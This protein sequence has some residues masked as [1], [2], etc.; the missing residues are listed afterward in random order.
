MVMDFEFSIIQE[1]Q[2]NTNIMS[3]LATLEYKLNTGASLN[4][5]LN[6]SRKEFEDNCFGLLKTREKPLPLGGG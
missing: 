3:I 4:K 6:A 5:K 1:E 2:L